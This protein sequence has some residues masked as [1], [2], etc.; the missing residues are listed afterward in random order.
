MGEKK[1]KHNWVILPLF[2]ETI[3]CSKCHNRKEIYEGLPCYVPDP[4]ELG[5][6]DKPVKYGCFG[7]PVIR[8]KNI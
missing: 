4:M 3:I 6:E 5:W 1:W 8:E 7:I 2:S